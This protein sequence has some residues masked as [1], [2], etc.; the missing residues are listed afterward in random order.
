[1]EH[2][3]GGLRVPLTI[4]GAIAEYP[5][6]QWRRHGEDWGGH[7]PPSSLQGQF[8]NLSNPVRKMGG[9]GRGYVCDIRPVI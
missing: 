1:M 5:S 2:L 6:T 3:Y 4:L 9:G 7:V 8:S